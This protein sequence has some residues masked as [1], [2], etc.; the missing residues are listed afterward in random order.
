[1]TRKCPQCQKCLR[2]TEHDEVCPECGFEIADWFEKNQQG[3][4]EAFLGEDS[5]GDT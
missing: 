2:Y 3:I 5:E 4:K 1:M